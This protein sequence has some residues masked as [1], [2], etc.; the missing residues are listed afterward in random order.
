MFASS[1]SKFILYILTNPE[2]FDIIP[3]SILIVVVFP[4]PLCPNKQNICDS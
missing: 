1:I 3:V 4:A 2:V